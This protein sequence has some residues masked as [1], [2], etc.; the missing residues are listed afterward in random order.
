MENRYFKVV[1]KCGHVGRF[2]CIWI[3]FAICAENKQE[4]ADKIR[5]EGRV[6]RDH[7]DFIKE[8]EEISF[9]TFMKLKAKNDSDPYLHCKNI[10][11]QNAIF[12]FEERVEVDEYNLAKL[13]K[14][15][16]K[17]N[18][19]KFRKQKAKTQE[20]SYNRRVYE[21]YMEEHAI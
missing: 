15:T 21:F 13:E 16:S 5:E 4:A 2:N 20:R 1:T 9:D 17:R 7:K 3:D 14:K 8:I 10:Q 6:K 11:E 19:V 12:G 18:S